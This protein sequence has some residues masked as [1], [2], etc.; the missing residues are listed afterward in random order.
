MRMSD[1]FGMSLSTKDNRAADS[2]C[3]DPNA[4][5]SLIAHESTSKNWIGIGPESLRM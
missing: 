2:V 3:H 4:L 5:E 1:A